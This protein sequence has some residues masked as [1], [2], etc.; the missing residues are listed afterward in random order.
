[1]VKRDVVER[2]KVRGGKG[3]YLSRLHLI[4][5]RADGRSSPGFANGILVAGPQQCSL[6]GRFRGAERGQGT[7]SHMLAEQNAAQHY[8]GMLCCQCEQARFHRTRNPSRQ[9]QC[10]IGDY[11]RPTRTVSERIHVR[12]GKKQLRSKSP[13]L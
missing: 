11:T 2:E 12:E 13:S 3:E 4:W 10:I 6:C 7:Q 8:T 1:M 9:Q 5:Q